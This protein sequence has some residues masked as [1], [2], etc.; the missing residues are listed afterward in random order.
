MNTTTYRLD[1][2]PVVAN[3]PGRQNGRAATPPLAAPPTPRRPAADP[4]DRE[5]FR[6]LNAWTPWRLGWRLAKDVIWDAEENYG[7]LRSLVSA[8]L[9]GRVSRET[10]A[11]RLAKCDGCRHL[12]Q[13]KSTYDPVAA[14][15]DWLA[16][17]FYGGLVWFFWWGGGLIVAAGFVR[18]ITGLRGHLPERP[19][20]FCAGCGCGEHPLAEL[21][22]KAALEDAECPAGAWETKHGD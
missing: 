4:W 14:L 19:A 13:R 15:A 7:Q 18:C 22:W 5:G 10:K 8:Y 17:T 3:P 1:P 11:A 2:M 20:R 21:D 12:I 16:L 6:R 9:G